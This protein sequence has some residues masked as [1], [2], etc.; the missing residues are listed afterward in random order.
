MVCHP[1]TDVSHTKLGSGVGLS[2]VCIPLDVWNTEAWSGS[3]AD[4][5]HILSNNDTKVNLWF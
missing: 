2:T 3:I 5:R 4:R 1:R